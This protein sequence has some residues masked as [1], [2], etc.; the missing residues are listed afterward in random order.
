MYLDYNRKMHTHICTYGARAIQMHTHIC[1]YSA[2]AI[3]M[4]THIRYMSQETLQKPRIH[5]VSNP[6][7][8][9]GI[10][11]DICRIIKGY[12]QNHQRASA[13]SSKGV[14]GII[15]G[16]P[17]N[18]QRVSAESSKGTCKFVARGECTPMLSM[19]AG[20]SNSSV[21]EEGR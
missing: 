18:R 8:I 9:C 5:Q 19:L 11:E 20:L 15:K 1:T 21:E 3:Q 13:E 4:H 6:Q 12:P 7:F 14:R 17:Q 16:C 2:R 10:V